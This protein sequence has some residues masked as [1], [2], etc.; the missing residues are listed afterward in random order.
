MPARTLASEKGV[1]LIEDAG[2]LDEV[3]GLVEWPVPL[4]GR[5]GD[6]FMDVPQEVLILSMRTHQKYFATRNADGSLAPWFVPV[7]NLT[8]DDGGAAIVAGNEK[9]L[10]ARGC[11]MPGSSGIRIGRDAGKPSG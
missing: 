7:S 11:L 9:V 3:A 1:A 2:L 4:I 5:I 8:A 6:A 10:R